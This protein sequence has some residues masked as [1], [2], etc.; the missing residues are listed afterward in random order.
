MQ[1]GTCG[2]SKSAKK[3]GFVAYRKIR[4]LQIPK[5]QKRLGPRI[6]NSQSVTFAEGPQF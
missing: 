4:K 2:S 3:L 6:E 1:M 5:S